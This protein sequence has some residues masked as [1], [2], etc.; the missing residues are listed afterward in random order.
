MSNP[1]ADTWDN[2]T[3]RIMVT[4]SMLG[5]SKPINGP[6]IRQPWYFEN[7]ST[8]TASTLSFEGIQL[9]R[10]L[11]KFASYLIENSRDIEPKYVK[12]VEENFWDLLA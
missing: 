9:Q 1:Y 7:Q 11:S 6:L 4:R 3:D 8:P 10:A 12:I 2:Y 5:I